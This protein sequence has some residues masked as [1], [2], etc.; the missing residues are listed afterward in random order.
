MSLPRHT[1]L[2]GCRPAQAPTPSAGRPTVPVRRPGGVSPR[3]RAARSPEPPRRSRGRFCRFCRFCHADWIRYVRIPPCISAVSARAVVPVF[4]LV[5]PNEARDPSPCRVANPTGDSRCRHESG[6]EHESCAND[7]GNFADSN[8]CNTCNICMT[9]WESGLSGS[10]RLSRRRGR[11]TSTSRNSRSGVAARAGGHAGGHAAREDFPPFPPSHPPGAIQR[12]SPGSEDFPQFPLALP[13]RRKLPRARRWS[14]R[15]GGLSAISA[16]SSAG[17]APEVVSGCRRLSAIPAGS[18][19]PGRT[20][21]WLAGRV[22]A[23]SAVPA[24]RSDHDAPSS[25]WVRQMVA[26]DGLCRGLGRPQAFA[27]AFP[28][29]SPRRRPAKRVRC[30][31]APDSAHFFSIGAVLAGAGESRYQAPP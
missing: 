22:S 28:P 13:C 8:N 15:A 16:V 10:R 31:E 11:A 26:D 2:S 20:A 30:H 9:I 7:G 18:A 29:A 24:A 21:Q 3:G 12:S 6:A 19:V 17:C 1:S 4:R 27:R 23:V 25:R 5:I 14:C